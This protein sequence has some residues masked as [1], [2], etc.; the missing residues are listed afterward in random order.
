MKKHIF[1][2]A[3]LSTIFALSVGLI[4]TANKPHKEADAYSATSLTTTIDLNDCTEQEIRSYYSNLNSLSTSER[5]GTNLLKNLKPILKDGQQYLNY[6]TGDNIWKIY[7]ITDRD[8]EKSPASAISHG[9]YNSSTNKITNYTYGSSGDNPYIHALYVNRNVNNQTRAWGDHSQNNWGINREHIWAKSHGFQDKG[10]GGA[11]G[12]PMHLWAGNGHANNIHS[13]NFFAFVDK[14]QS[15]TNCGSSYSYLKGNL[16][17]QPK[18]AINNSSKDVFEPQDCDKGDI[19]RAVFYMVAR[20]NNYAG[21]T[22][23]IDTNDPNLVLANDM[24]QNDTT[25]TSTASRSYAM[26]LLSDLLAWNKLD[27]VDEY[28]IHRNNLLFRNYTKNRNPFI[29][30]PEWADAIWGTADLDG[31][32]YNSSVTSYATPASDPIGSS[33]I[34]QTFSISN[35]SFNLEVGE[36]TTISARNAE[37]TINW[38]VGNS[39]VV[40]LDKTS[41]SNNDPVTITALA[42][43]T[44][45]I[46]ATSGSDSAT[47]TITVSEATS[48]EYTKVAAYDFSVGN[49]SSSPAYTDEGLLNRFHNSSDDSLTD[50]VIDVNDTER[51][52]PAYNSDYLNYGIKMGTS[53]A[54]G[55]FIV[56]LNTNVTKVLVDVAGWGTGDKLTVGDAAPQI[57]GVAYDGNNPFKTLTYNI[58]STNEVEFTFTNRGFIRSIEFYISGSP[59]VVEDVPQNHLTSVTRIAGLYGDASIVQT[60]GPVTN[61]VNVSTLGMDNADDVSNIDLGHS[62]AMNGAKA[63]GT[64]TPKYYTSDFS[65]RVYNGNTITFESANTMTEIAFTAVNN[66]GGENLTVSTGTISNDV[67]TGEATS[68]TFTNTGSAQFRFKN[69]NI[70]YT[71]TTSSISVTGMSFK[72]GITIPQDDWDA[73]ADNW[74]ISDYGVM[75][76]KENTLMNVYHEDTVEDAHTAGKK[77]QDLHKGNG[78]TPYTYD[79]NYLFTVKLNIGVNIAHNLRFVASPYIVIDDVYYFLGE[80]RCSINELAATCLTTGETNLPDDALAYLTTH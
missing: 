31:T 27:P 48:G 78:D 9:T 23:G 21:A 54:T 49:T 17:G 34:P 60:T 45:T 24:T 79:A 14:S 71:G 22:S 3:T 5:Q 42:A 67:W 8:W 52:Y 74:E 62:M 32:N 66:Y 19:A 15:Y 35:S 43:G 33:S 55:S 77:L 28:E 80:I 30:F 36:T 10:A 70:T 76:V 51:V 40:S 63:S 38:T 65:V 39:S 73:I 46:T 69:V 4:V 12:D 58:T 29:D 61:V 59:I 26:G 68:V 75:I 6:D 2:I 64:N 57:P 20:Y 47:C 13:N 44:T 18:N 41:T 56:S 16:S 7:E 72:F 1:G 25:G 50:I 53:S 37:S 11:R